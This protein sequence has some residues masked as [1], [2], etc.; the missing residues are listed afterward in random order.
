MK[1]TPCSRAAQR[2]SN[3][4]TS[5]SSTSRQGD[6]CVAPLPPVTHLS[7]AEGY[8]RSRVVASA[9]GGGGPEPESSDDDNVDDTGEQA[10][11]G[12]RRQGAGRKDEGQGSDG[13]GDDGS[14]SQ[15]GRGG[16]DADGPMDAEANDQQLSE[17][18]ARGYGWPD[19]KGGFSPAVCY[20][21]AVHDG[22]NQ[23]ALLLET[24]NCYSFLWLK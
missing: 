19:P 9:G 17:A 5:L 18:L 15:G 4:G 2:S 22:E 16:G 11:R 24:Y 10:G 23:M 7:P 6:G 8:Q 20:E 1:Q 3:G 13:G 14:G 21:E 12:G